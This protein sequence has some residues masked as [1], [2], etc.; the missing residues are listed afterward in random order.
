ME[1]H[2]KQEEKNLIGP[3]V[4]SLRKARDMTRPELLVQLHLRGVDL[5]VSS[6]SAIERQRRK[7]RDYEL[8]ALADVFGISPDDL[9]PPERD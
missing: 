8:A 4:L 7:V 1:H 3:T 9:F 6:F 5:S 2:R